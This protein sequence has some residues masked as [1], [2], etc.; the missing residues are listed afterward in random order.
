MRSRSPTDSALRDSSGISTFC[1]N[2]RRSCRN[3]SPGRD[4][5]ISYDWSPGSRANLSR[6]GPNRATRLF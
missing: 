4:K 6:T 5:T 2:S 3:P 1:L